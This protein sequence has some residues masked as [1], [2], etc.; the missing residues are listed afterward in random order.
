M[1]S[2]ASRY[3]GSVLVHLVD[4]LEGN[5][6]IRRAFSDCPGFYIV[7]EKVPIYVKYATRRH[8]PWTFNFQKE[9]R[10]RYKQLFEIYGRS[11]VTFVCG[12]DG[13]VALEYEELT[14]ILGKD[15]EQQGSVS[16]YRKLN[17]MYRIRGRESE[18]SR[19]IARNSL[20]N[21]L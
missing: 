19:K 4:G 7:N 15:F 1:I 12:R 6:G 5:I 16:I 9:H 21:A 14:K 18:L 13:I 10:A 17:H 8:G 11:V 2:E 20:L 3:Y